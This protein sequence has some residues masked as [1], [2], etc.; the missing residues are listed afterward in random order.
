[1]EAR[2]IWKLKDIHHLHTTLAQTGLINLGLHFGHPRI[3]FT[4]DDLEGASQKDIAE[5][6]H[7]SP[8]SLAMSL[9]RLQKGGFI[10]RCA[11]ANDQRV[12]KIQLTEKGRL[13]IRVCRFQV[14]MFD[15][16]MIAGFSA[17]EQDQLSAFLARIYANLANVRMDEIEAACRTLM[18]NS[19]TDPDEVNHA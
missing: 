15:R 17:E 9:K 3:L 1:M 8:A 13:A 12:N 5:R 16:Q 19:N 11:D 6:L 18:D 10:E 14:S 4:I 7:V 2:L